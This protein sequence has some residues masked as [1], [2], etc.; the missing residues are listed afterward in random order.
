MNT[1]A[2]LLSLLASV[3]SV[4]ATVPQILK[5]LRRASTND[6]SF[7]CFF[8]HTVAGVLWAFY[9]GMIGAYV[10]TVEAALVAILNAI[11]VVHILETRKPG[12]RYTNPPTSA[13]AERR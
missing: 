7:S 3:L 11:V 4:G 2:I 8:M 6:L 13:Q 9:G 10:L 1:P 5:I 12:E